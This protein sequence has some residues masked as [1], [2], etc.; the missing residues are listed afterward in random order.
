[1]AD[2]NVGGPILRDK[3]WFCVSGQAVDNSFTITQDPNFPEHPPRQVYGF[4]GLAKL[5]WRISTRNELSL[6]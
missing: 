3:I 6:R 1:M 4:D 2:L 5:T